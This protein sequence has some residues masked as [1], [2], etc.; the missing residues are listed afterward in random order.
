MLGKHSLVCRDDI[1]TCFK[2]L[3]HVGS[4]GLQPPNQHGHHFNFW[5]GQN[6]LQVAR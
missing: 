6:R 1:F 5:I 4:G 2:Q 3:Q